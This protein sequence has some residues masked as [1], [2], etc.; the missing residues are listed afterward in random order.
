MSNLI[1]SISANVKSD[2]FYQ[3]QVG[4]LLAQSVWMPN[5]IGLIGA[6]AGSDWFSQFQCRIV[7]GST[8]AHARSYSLILIQCQI[9]MARSVQMTNLIGSISSNVESDWFSWYQ[10]RL[11]LAQAVSNL[12][13]AQAV[14][15]SLS[16]PNL[17]AHYD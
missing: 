4:I 16:M 2:W 10:Y 14:P 8:G 11:L 5:L 12:S 3:C 17:I 15:L 6:N 13:G 7:F 9:W 1:G